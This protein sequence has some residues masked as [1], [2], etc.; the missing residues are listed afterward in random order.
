[1][2][3]DDQGYGLENTNMYGVNEKKGP[4]ESLKTGWRK[5]RD[6]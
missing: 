5:Q 2:R 3:R 6:P 4:W 1:M